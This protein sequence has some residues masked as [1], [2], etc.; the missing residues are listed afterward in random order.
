MQ[1]LKVDY[2]ATGAA[3]LRDTVASRLR[4]RRDAIE[5]AVLARVDGIAGEPVTAEE[6]V[7]VEGLRSAV[8]VALSYALDVLQQGATVPPPPALLTQARLAARS[9]VSLGTVLRR[10]FAGYS[11]LT[12]ALMEEAVESGFD[13]ATL[14]EALREGG[15]VFEHLVGAVSEEHASESRDR[16]APRDGHRARRVQALLAGE[17]VDTSSLVYDFDGW[18]VGLVA[19]GPDGGP[20][21]QQLSTALERRSLVVRW[22]IER[23][24]GWIGG[25]RP[26][27]RDEIASCLEL[28]LPMGMSVA[29]GEPAR[30]M[31]GWRLTHRQAVS[32]LPVALKFD[33]CAVRYLDTAVLANLL[34]DDVLLASLRQIYLAPI[35]ADRSGGET[36]LETLRAYY[37]ADRNVSSAAAVLGVSRR[38]VSNRLQAVEDLLGRSLLTD[39]VEIELALRLQEHEQRIREPG[40]PG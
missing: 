39:T 19:T 7:Y 4:G 31:G 1:S 21:F 5:E 10:Y 18:H 22:D 24:Y 30:E 34:A 3:T 8:T 25:R 14:A 27:S 16:V 40:Q 15:I 37:A 12:S 32:V 29:V 23:T 20:I 28:E 26:F 35:A 11:L 33:G 2:T 17:P 13:R 9:G 36:L 6:A 38:T